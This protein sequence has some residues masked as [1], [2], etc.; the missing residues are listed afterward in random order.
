MLFTKS[1]ATEGQVLVV[2]VSTHFCYSTLF[3]SLLTWA[4]LICPLNLYSTLIH[5]IHVEQHDSLILFLELLLFLSYPPPHYLVN[6]LALKPLTGDRV[7]DLGGSKILFI[8][9]IHMN[10][11]NVGFN[12]LIMRRHNAYKNFRTRQSV[13][14][15][16]FCCFQ[17]YKEN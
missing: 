11:E 12:G 5:E 9:C 16:D 10:D 8:Q 4:H 3:E 14:N 15:L 6:M 17:S 7:R 13:L 2:G 1:T